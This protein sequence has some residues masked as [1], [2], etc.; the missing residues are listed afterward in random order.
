MRRA[1]L[2]VVPPGAV[3]V[4]VMNAVPSYTITR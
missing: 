1:E 3:L 2:L 4:T